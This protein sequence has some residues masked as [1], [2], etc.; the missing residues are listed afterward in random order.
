MNIMNES[1][2]PDII[3]SEDSHSTTENELIL[4]LEKG[5]GKKY[6]RFVMAVLSSI[7]WVGSVIGATA[8]FTAEKDQEKLNELQKLW[9]AEHQE[10][11]KSL[12]ETFVQM[13]SR[14]DEFGE[15]IKVRLESQEYLTLVRK[16]FHSWDQADTDE[17]RKMYQKLITNAAAITL[18]PDDLIRLFINWLDV[19]HEAHFIVIKAIYKHTGI[20]RAQIWDSFHDARPREDSAEADLFR[21]LI[22]DLSTGGV[23]RQERDTN[24]Y[25]Q[26]I[27][28]TPARASKYGGSQVS[29]TMES[30]FEDSKSYELTELGKQFVHYVMEE[31]VT[32]IG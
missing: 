30:A 7:P 25:G 18:S 27:K 3:P 17:K 2:K 24:V 13:F 23:I 22:R 14:L 32:Q 12:G 15:E 28:K 31:V 20:T 19:Y 21:Y 4:E 6:I 9:L 26:F 11:I 16:T 29:K 10:K 1:N 5:K 8:S